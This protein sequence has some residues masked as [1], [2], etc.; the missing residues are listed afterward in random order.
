MKIYDLN[1]EQFRVAADEQEFGPE[2]VAAAERVAV[3]MTQGWCPQWPP[4]RSY[5]QSMAAEDGE[6]GLA[7]FLAVY[8]TEP[9]GA[10][11]M[12]FKESVFGNYHIPYIRYYR[13]GTLIAESNFISRD[14]FLESFKNHER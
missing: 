12:Q 2:V 4:V 7:V 14:G 5:L 13:E 6:D 10:D 8:D 9:W 11:F 1:E 3:V